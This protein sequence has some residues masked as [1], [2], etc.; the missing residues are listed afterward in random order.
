[1]SQHIAGERAVVAIDAAKRQFVAVVMSGERQGLRTIKWRHPDHTRALIERLSALA[2]A[3][4]EMV[5]ESAA[6][7]MGLPCFDAE[8]AV[9]P[10]ERV[11]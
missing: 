1:L 7:S 9:I 3:P 10:C 8:A 4:V 2:A 11:D 6:T 5:L